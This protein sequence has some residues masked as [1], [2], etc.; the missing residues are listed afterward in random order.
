MNGKQAKRL[1]KIG[2][3]DKKSKRQFQA[4]D[5]TTKGAF[6]RQVDDWTA[7]EA[8]A[9]KNAELSTVEEVTA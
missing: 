6:S 2:K 5:H 8:W 4:L 1:R 9:K 3:G 7:I